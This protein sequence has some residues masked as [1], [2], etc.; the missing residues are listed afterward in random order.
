MTIIRRLR[1][2]EDQFCPPLETAFSRR[3]GER[4][5]A[6]RRRLAESDVPDCGSRGAGDRGHDDAPAGTGAW[7]RLGR[8]RLLFDAKAA[9]AGGRSRTPMLFASAGPWL[10]RSPNGRVRAL[11]IDPTKRTSP[12]GTRI[13]TA[14][15]GAIGM[16]WNICCKCLLPTVC[17]MVL[18]SCT[19]RSVSPLNTLRA[20][21][22]S[23][24][25]GA[26]PPLVTESKATQQR[27]R[28]ALLKPA[29]KA[30]PAA[31]PAQRPENDAQP[32]RT[33]AFVVP[34]EELGATVRDELNT[35][36]STELSFECPSQ[37]R[38]GFAD[39]ARLIIR[40]TLNDQL[41]DRLEARGIP[42]SYAAAIVVHV[43]ADLTSRDKDALDIF[44]EMSPDKRRPSDDRVWRV[45]A[46]YPGNHELNLKVTLIARIPSA[47]EVQGIPVNLSRSI[48]VVGGENS[49][50]PYRPGIAGYL[51][52]LLCA[53]IAWTLWRNRRRPLP[54]S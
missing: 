32:L 23:A 33:L 20:P 15:T 24:V 37:M 44:V 50:T 29:S 43:D 38:A 19:K 52:G 22:L 16:S 21:P 10:P 26:A 41:R 18:A 51:T 3:L 2:L 48:S 54:H 11:F 4:V 45:R 8:S 30:S 9:L 36:A 14:W 49:P 35:L 25:R 5:E 17:V 53:W 27:N 28:S 31:H 6:A 1:R 39:H 46:L 34:V 47:G 42:A 7:F 40:R 13:A 12:Y